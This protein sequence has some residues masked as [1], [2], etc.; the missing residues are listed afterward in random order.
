VPKRAAQDT[1]RRDS[2]RKAAADSAARAQAAAPHPPPGGTVIL[3]TSRP[4][5]PGSP[6]AVPVPVPAQTQQVPATGATPGTLPAPGPGTFKDPFLAKSA[7]ESLR[8]IGQKHA[9]AA[10]EIAENASRAAENKLRLDTSRRA[11]NRYEIEIH[12]KFALAAACVIFVVLGA[13]LA[14]RFP[15]GGV[16]LVLLVSLVVFALYYV[17]LIGGESLA[18]KGIVPPFWAM[19]GTNV[20]LTIVGVVLLLRMGR[21]ESAGRGTDWGE[22]IDRLR[23]FVNGRRRPSTVLTEE[24]A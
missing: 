8:A 9:V 10:E 7:S 21:E 1:A 12:K 20:V 13:P 14:L 17:G 11:K 4:P 24:T 5:A 16:G 19:W 18:N 15:R 6:G 2:L 22:R 23:D 3:G